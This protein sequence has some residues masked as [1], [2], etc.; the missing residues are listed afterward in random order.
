LPVQLD[1]PGMQLPVVPEP[2]LLVPELPPLQQV[3]GHCHAPFSHRGS[4]L[5]PSEQKQS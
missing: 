3:G 4:Q 2:P 1:P 5:E